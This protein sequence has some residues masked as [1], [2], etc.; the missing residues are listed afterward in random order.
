MQRR[1]LIVAFIIPMFLM[2]LA[3][4]QLIVGG[5]A[6]P[7]WITTIAQS[8]EHDALTY[9]R[10]LVTIE[11]LLALVFAFV[12]RQLTWLAFIVVALIAF[13]S[14]AECSAAVRRELLVPLVTAAALFALSV[15]ILIA[16]SRANKTAHALSRSDES[17]AVATTSLPM[18]LLML[19]LMFVST[20][21]AI[22]LPMAPRTFADGVVTRASVDV[23]QNNSRIIELAPESWIGQDISA[24]EIGLFAPDVKDIVGGKNGIIVLYNP[25]CGSCHDLFN[26]YFSEPLDIPVAAIL[27]PPS[28]Q[29]SV[30][31]SEFPEEV[32]CPECEM[33]TLPTGPLWLV[34][35]PVVLGLA[36][37]IVTCVASED[38]TPCF[39]QP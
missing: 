2:L 17:T 1:T 25:R 23:P 15:S 35:P 31:P 36:D 38:P 14:L 33:M 21:I 28:P 5:N 10:V 32:T 24:T 26:V 7:I 9:L 27:I 20:G 37:G 4:A 13:V 3:I 16:L 34:S 30:L 8:Q 12:G 22:N 18:V 19:L 6:L 39:L 29:E 11:I